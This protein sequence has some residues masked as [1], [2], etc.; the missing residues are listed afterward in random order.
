LRHSGLQALC[1]SGC[2][3]LGQL[4]VSAPKLAALELDEVADLAAV[5]LQQVS[6]G[7]DL[8]QH[9]ARFCF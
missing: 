9:S 2:R 4:V 3:S 8:L 5:S 1:V 7:V 6:S